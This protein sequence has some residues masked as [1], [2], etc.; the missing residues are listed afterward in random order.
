MRRTMGLSYLSVGLWLAAVPAWAQPVEDPAAVVKALF[1][2][3]DELQGRRLRE[4]AD[5]L[6]LQAGS[7]VADVGCGGGEIALI[8]SR[9][10]GPKGHVWAEDIR[11]Q[12]LKSTRTLMKKHHTR[13]VSVILG[14]VADPKLPAGRLDGISLFL[15]Y[16]ELYKYPEML[17]RFHE[18]LKPD[19][20]LTILDP[21][22][23]KT[24]SRPREA[25]MKNHV[26]WPDIATDDLQKAGFEVLFREEHFVDDPDSEGT[27]WLIVARPV[28]KP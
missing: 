27:L 13:N 23:H 21:L 18:A 25:Q 20:R 16:H 5:Y 19:G 4:I 11:P 28:V 15:V 26:L 12:A 6:K 8:W 3:D 1:P 17:A 24:A 2:K 10:V 9:A 7:Q 14:E 22:P